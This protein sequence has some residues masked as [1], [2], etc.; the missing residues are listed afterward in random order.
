MS[1]PRVSPFLPLLQ[2]SPSCAAVQP[3]TA[4][5]P[6]TTLVEASICLQ[7]ASPLNTQCGFSNCS[8]TS[9]GTAWHWTMFQCTCE[10]CRRACAETAGDPGSAYRDT[11]L[12]RHRFSRLDDLLGVDTPLA[13][14]EIGRADSVPVLVIRRALLAAAAAADTDSRMSGAL[15]DFLCSD[16]MMAY[17]SSVFCSL[18]RTSLFV[19]GSRDGVQLFDRLVLRRRVELEQR[20]QL[21]VPAELDDRLLFSCM[22][23]VLFRVVVAYDAMHEMRN[24]ARLGCDAARGLLLALQLFA[25]THLDLYLYCDVVQNWSD[26]YLMTPTIN[27]MVRTEWG[28]ALHESTEGSARD[29]VRRMRLSESVL[30]SPLERCYPH[31]LRAVYAGEMLDIGPMLACANFWTQIDDAGFNANA[32]GSGSS[33]GGGGSDRAQVAAFAHIFVRKVADHICLS[34]SFCRMMSAELANQPALVAFVCNMLEQSMLGNNEMARFHPLWRARLAIRR[35]FHWDRFEISTWCAACHGGTTMRAAC[36]QCGDRVP[37]EKSTAHKKHNCDM[38]S[39]M[40]RN[41]RFLYFSAKEM[42]VYNVRSTGLLDTLLD[43]DAGWSAHHRIVRDALDDARRILSRTFS[44]RISVDAIRNAQAAIERELTLQH[45]VSKP[46]MRPLCKWPAFYQQLRK[47]FEAIAA[48]SFS[49]S[50]WTGYQQPQDFLL[51]PLLEERADPEAP[52][53]ERWPRFY[54]ADVPLAHL[55]GR[56]W[57]DV[58][59]LRHIADVARYCETVHYDIMPSL[60]SSIGVSPA[61]QAMLYDMQFAAQVRDSSDSRISK[62]CRTLS[63]QHTVDY[64]I[65]HYFVVCMHDSGIIKPFPLDADAA[66]AQARALHHRQQTPEWVPLRPGT[67]RLFICRRHLEVCADIPPPVSLKEAM[68]ISSGSLLGAKTAATVSGITTALYSPTLQGLVCARPLGSALLEKW[69]QLGLNRAQWIDDDASRVRS[70]IRSR[71][72]ERGCTGSRLESRSALGVAWSVG[73]QTYTLCVKCG[74]VCVWR[75]SCLTSEGMTC[76]YEVRISERNCYSDITQFVSQRERPTAAST[77]SG[78]LM[79]LDEPLLMPEPA[80]QE[81]GDLLERTTTLLFD[82]SADDELLH[83]ASLDRSAAVL[84]GGVTLHLFDTTA[85]AAP[86][87]DLI[88]SDDSAEVEAA[89]ERRAAEAQRRILPGARRKQTG[90]KRPLESEMH[91]EAPPECKYTESEWA[92]LDDRTRLFRWMPTGITYWLNR[93]RIMNSQSLAEDARADLLS[94]LEEAES[95]RITALIDADYYEAQMER[96]RLSDVCGESMRRAQR[97]VQADRLSV[98]DVVRLRE[99]FMQHGTIERRM[100]VVCAQCRSLCDVR[101]HFVRITVDNA[102]DTLIDG[103]TGERTGRRGLMYVYLCSKCYKMCERLLAVKPVPLASD[104]ALYV[105]AARQKKIERAIAH[106][107]RH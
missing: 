2:S 4:P 83:A 102:H 6:L 13:D 19:S 29:Y 96:A 42:F 70:I 53:R 54:A 61:A 47:N 18:S 101:S 38:C 25:D 88:E 90:V 93:T 39:F 44:E 40:R 20:Y 103:Q 36:P 55:G 97:R 49:S 99:L 7:C 79:S 87:P 35:T 10:G 74:A 75:D 21:V 15:R 33:V 84:G 82:A 17:E 98:G 27:T 68:R 64:F 65:L 91:R 57:C 22:R 94:E 62:M 72:S 43:A 77:S 73:A 8:L 86:T 48:K 60:L 5:P 80:M 100:E 66:I 89:Q 81:R 50:N 1:A 41:R 31:P 92:A 104:I 32:T 30:L 63:T 9:N 26:S 76:S 46:T 34:R 12:E 37:D 95:R 58:Y 69:S 52:P 3:H 11:L 14:I 16:L 106:F 24:N 67:D 51:A 85:A 45:D 59:E 56:R 28:Q 105:K 78:M 71:H 23:A 107:H